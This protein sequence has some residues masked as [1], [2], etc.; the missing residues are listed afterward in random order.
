M[1]LRKHANMPHVHQLAPPCA[2][3]F[4]PCQKASQQAGWLEHHEMEHALA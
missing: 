2:T 3:G 1:G 4:E